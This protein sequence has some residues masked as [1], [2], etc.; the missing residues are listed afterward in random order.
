M[1]LSLL[2]AIIVSVSESTM[3]QHSDITPAIFRII[4]LRNGAK[5]RALQRYRFNAEEKLWVCNRIVSS[6]EDIESKIDS[7]I[8]IFC[9]RY[10]LNP[11]IITAWI[12]QYADGLS[13]ITPNCPIDTEGVNAIRGLIAIGARIGET[14]ENKT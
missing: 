11:N 1:L 2:L 8:S 5:Y 9:E 12:N 14:D 10:H 6:C 7:D 3:E 13:F 4:P